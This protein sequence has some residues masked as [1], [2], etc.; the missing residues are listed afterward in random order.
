[1]KNV[2]TAQ[3]FFYV[4]VLSVFA[5]AGALS[6]VGGVSIHC[7]PKANEFFGLALFLD[8]CGLGMVLVAGLMIYK[9]KRLPEIY[10][11]ASCEW[12]SEVARH[13][14]TCVACGKP[15]AVTGKLKTGG[16]YDLS[17]SQHR[18]HQTKGGRNYLNTVTVT[19]PRCAECYSRHVTLFVVSLL[20]AVAGL[21]VGIVLGIG[22]G[23]GP[24][25]GLPVAGTAIG[26]FA[27]QYAGSQILLSQGTKPVKRIRKEQS[28]R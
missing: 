5:I 25:L 22:A 28:F 15:R 2:P 24:T 6:L 9:F 23:G 4:S 27:T 19:L 10:A 7:G 16:T 20:V 3:L 18:H 12:E 21:I 13:A 8:I 17:L 26:W 1:M 11:E 14:V